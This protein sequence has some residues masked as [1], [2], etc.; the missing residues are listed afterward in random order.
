MAKREARVEI[1]VDA[2][3][4][5]TLQ[6]LRAKF[7][8][9]SETP[10]DTFS[11][12]DLRRRVALLSVGRRRALSHICAQAL[13]QPKI[14]RDEVTRVFLAKVMAVLL[15]YSLPW[16]P[17]LLQPRPEAALAEVQFS[18]FCFLDAAA[19]DRHRGSR[20]LLHLLEQYLLTI[21]RDS[22]HA[23]WMAGDLLGDHWP[24]QESLGVLIS[25]ASNARHSA[26]RLAAI[27]GLSHALER[28]NKQQQWAIV[29]VLKRVASKDRSSR[30]RS[31]A[32]SV[33]GI[34]RGT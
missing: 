2:K 17:G 20:E 7:G 25:A 33:L 3:A 4:H 30:V 1:A 27:H 32:S 12:A 19:G 24:L 28:G 21:A 15:P 14:L 29:D 9:S 8:L 16:L 11:V 6:R 26:G 22:A 10:I 18:L 34:M 13:G 31:Y 5:E 23:A